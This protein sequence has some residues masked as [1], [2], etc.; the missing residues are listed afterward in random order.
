MHTQIFQYSEILIYNICHVF[1]NI[2]VDRCRIAQ[3]HI[4]LVFDSE[5]E[6]KM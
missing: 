4:P 6:S 2:F 5:G 3:T 1:V